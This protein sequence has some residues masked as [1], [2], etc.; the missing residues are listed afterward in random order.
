[1]MCPLYLTQ[2]VHL[3]FYLLSPI[4]REILHTSSSAICAFFCFVKRQTTSRSDTD[5]SFSLFAGI[6][7]FLKFSHFNIFFWY[8][9][10][11]WSLLAQC[12][13]H[14]LTRHK[15]LHLSQTFKS[16]TKVLKHVYKPLGAIWARLIKLRNIQKDSTDFRRISYFSYKRARF[17]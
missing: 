2:T 10:L 1:M 4:K 17:R 7:D 14:K 8:F 5:Q 12:I 15:M 13:R 9:E 6:Q 16:H 11:F 3:N